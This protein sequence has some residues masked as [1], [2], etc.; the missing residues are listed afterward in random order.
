MSE[1]L[2]PIPDFSEKEKQ[3]LAG[4]R[5]LEIVG[6]PSPTLDTQG[7][8][9]YWDIYWDTYH[10]QL[11]ILIPNEDHHEEAES[12]E[13]DDEN[14]NPVLLTAYEEESEI[15]NGPWKS[16]IRFT[17]STRPYRGKFFPD[18]ESRTELFEYCKAIAEYLAKESIADLVIAD[19]SARPLY[20]GVMEYWRKALSN[21]PMPK[22]YFIN[23]KGFKAADAMDSD[24]LNKTIVAPVF[25]D[26]RIEERGLV[27]TQGEIMQEFTHAYPRLFKD[28]QKPVLLF[29][30]CIHSGETIRTVIETFKEAGFS[31]LRIGSVSPAHADSSLDIDFYITDKLPEQGCF[32]FDQDRSIEKTFEHV[33][34]RP[35]SS[36]KRKDL[37][38]EL[39]MSIKDIVSEYMGSAQLPT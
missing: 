9:R 30:T 31:N 24:E 35:T 8:A 3:T 5:T 10:K 6:D 29:D 36:Q 4:Q 37:A 22:I 18:K 15:Y 16:D 25:K 2:D 1:K 7:R 12:E 23:P 28:K 39:R 17:G 33:Y 21:Q 34:S 13:D 20:V 26:D 38:R 32:P 14:D 27:R 11:D 19:R